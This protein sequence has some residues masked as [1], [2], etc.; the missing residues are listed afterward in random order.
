MYT[1]G[2]GTPNLTG[3]APFPTCACIYNRGETINHSTI[4]CNIFLQDSIQDNV[5]STQLP[6]RDT[7]SILINRLYLIKFSFGF[8]NK[9]I[10][11]RLSTQIIPCDI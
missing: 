9:L 11:N 10:T 2:T 5:T 4:Y 1:D 8:A 3:G 7:N 6:N